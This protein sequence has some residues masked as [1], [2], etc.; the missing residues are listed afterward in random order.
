MQYDK[1]FLNKIKK[2]KNKIIYA[3]V[4]ALSSDELP[5]EECIK[6]AE[7]DELKAQLYLG[8][9]YSRGRRV[10]KDYQKALKWYKKASEKDDLEAKCNLAVLYMDGAI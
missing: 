7:E 6:L 4:I 1:E 8:K 5:L 9:I 3:K 10:Q 2:E